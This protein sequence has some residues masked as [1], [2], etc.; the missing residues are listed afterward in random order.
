MKVEW[1]LGRWATAGRMAIVILLPATITLL[2]ACWEW[3][4]AGPLIGA[5]AVGTGVTIAAVEAAPSPRP[6]VS[7]ESQSGDNSNPVVAHSANPQS[8]DH[9]SGLVAEAVPAFTPSTT[10]PPTIAA[11]TDARNSRLRHQRQSKTQALKRSA[12]T[13]PPDRRAGPAVAASKSS[14]APAALPPNIA[15]AKDPPSVRM[16]HKRGSTT[17]VF[18]SSTKPQ[19]SEHRSGPVTANLAE[20]APPGELPA[21][22]IVH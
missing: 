11:A 17:Q 6:G 14:T 5:G 12:K 8:L 10:L 9:G 15:V 19:S 1:W 4:V 3:D 7:V 13:R 18:A 20:T 21:T 22:T 2:S 16:S